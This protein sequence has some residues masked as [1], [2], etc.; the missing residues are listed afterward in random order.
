MYEILWMERGVMME[1]NEV[2]K[3]VTVEYSKDE[4]TWAMLCHLTALAGF[5]GIPF[6]NILG[7]LIC[8]LLKK[9]EYPFV[10][11]QGKEA[12]NFQITLTIAAL[13]AGLLCLILIGIPILLA[14]II[15]GVVLSIM[16]GIKANDGVSYKY[17]FRIEFFK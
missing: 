16:A 5:I 9:E 3:K 11:E 8:W 2:E 4:R 12:L 15:G 10:N 6:G 14:I 13:I 1:G 7:P 17:P